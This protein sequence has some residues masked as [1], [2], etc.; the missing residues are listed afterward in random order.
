MYQ[1]NNKMKKICINILNNK[2]FK[3]LMT[4]KYRNNKF[5]LVKSQFKHLLM[6]KKLKIIKNYNNL[7]RKD[8][9]C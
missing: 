1:N 5:C 3:D 6:H 8:A 4:N 2:E 9:Q 7:L